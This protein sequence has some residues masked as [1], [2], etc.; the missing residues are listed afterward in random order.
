[1][2]NPPGI[3]LL[4]EL[5]G[6]AAERQAIAAHDLGTYE[7]LIQD[8][9]EAFD[10]PEFDENTACGI[11]YTSGTTGNPK[12]VLYS[13]RST[14]LHAMQVAIS[15]SSILREGQRVLSLVPLFHVNAWGLPYTCA[16][17]GASPV[18]LPARIWTGKACLS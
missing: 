13:H 15:F 10:W 2:K 12:G 4:S 16:L 5:A 14:V 8:Q 6:S 18:F 9:P 1:M 7:T 17:V 11:C 3:V